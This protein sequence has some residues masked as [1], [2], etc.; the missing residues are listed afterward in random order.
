MLSYIY[1]NPFQTHEPDERYLRSSIAFELSQLFDAHLQCGISVDH[2]HQF[3]VYRPAGVDH[4]LG[5]G[6][7][8][9][10]LLLKPDAYYCGKIGRISIRNSLTPYLQ[11]KNV[12]LAV[13]D[14]NWL[15]YDTKFRKMLVLVVMRAQKPVSLNATVFLSTVSMGTMTTV[16]FVQDC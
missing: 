10:H 11:S 12:S 4:T 15:E 2:W 16:S 13:Y 6:G 8:L 9:P 7:G 1:P 5:S 14:M 3:G